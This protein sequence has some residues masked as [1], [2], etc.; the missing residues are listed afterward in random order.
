MIG[1]IAQFALSW[2]IIWLVEKKGLGVLGFFPTNKRLTDLAIFLVVTAACS[3]SHFIMRMLFAEQRWILNPDLSF[4]LILEGVWWNIKSVLFEELIFRG[5][6][7]YIL[8]KRTGMWWGIIISSVAF[9]I[10]HWF[11]QEIFGDPMPM[12][13]T[14]LITGLMGVV[15]A[16]GYAKTF[17]LYVPIAIHLGWNLTRSVIFSET[18]IGDQLLIQVKPAAQV[19][20]SYFTYFVV[21]YLPM[22]S[23]MM[24]NFFLLKKKMPVEF[25]GTPQAG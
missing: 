9:G 3:A 25:P 5:V 12:L 10:Y 14:F 6:F 15:Y 18:V 16:Y 13:I 17:S 23:A 22:L 24:I 20:V 1:I 8:I 11:S 19:Q 4:K 2:L 7:L 21:V